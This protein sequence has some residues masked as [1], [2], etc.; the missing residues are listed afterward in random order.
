M[1]D[2]T[3]FGQ[4]DR[5]QLEIWPCPKSP[6][7]RAQVGGVNSSLE[8]R[9]SRGIF[10]SASCLMPTVAPSIPS[11]PEHASLPRTQEMSSFC[12]GPQLHG[13]LLDEI[14][15]YVLRLGTCHVP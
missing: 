10:L 6:F 7:K 4:P 9:S 2:R 3:F 13:H 11:S 12:L 5:K 15:I 1:E 8:G 14:D